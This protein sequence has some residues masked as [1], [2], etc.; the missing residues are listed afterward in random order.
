MFGRRRKKN[1]GA[2]AADTAEV[3]E[4][5]SAPPEPEKEADRHRAAGP[6][7]AS[8]DAPDVRRMDLGA[9]RV[10]IQPGTEIQV[11]VANQ[12]GQGSRRGQQIIGVTL[13]QG[14]SA[15]QIQPF[16]APKSSGVWDELRDELRSQVTGQ[17]GKV[18][19]FDGAFG[20]ELRAVVPV[21]GRKNEQGHQLGQRVRFIG[22]D[23]PR[24][25]LRGVVRG[26][27]AVKPEAMAAIDAL[28]Q[29]VVVV[30]GDS[31]VPPRDLL[32][33]TVPPEVQKSLAASGGR[34]A[35]PQA[36]PAVQPPGPGPAAPPPADP[37]SATPDPGIPAP[38]ADQDEPGTVDAD[39]AEPGGSGSAAADSSGSSGGDS[40]GGGGGGF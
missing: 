28:F 8:E 27:A 18:E 10:P 24:W 16:A 33:I 36:D 4:R 31:P 2:G 20:T 14:N 34:T 7:D 35:A 39:R 3:V 25:V 11:N 26:D 38:P 15:L 1:D 6:W 19:D 21:E 13:I 22:V 30:R 29:G 12:R 9:I 17:G 32:E 40:G 5:R 23:G 37:A